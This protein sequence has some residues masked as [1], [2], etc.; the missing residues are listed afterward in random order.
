MIDSVE[1][2]IEM[3]TRHLHIM[4]IVI[5]DEPIGIVKISNKTGYPHH[6]VRYSLR[7]LEETNLIKPTEQGAITTDQASDFVENLGDKV[8]NIQNTIGNMN[9]ET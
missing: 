2:E 4:R 3:V 5:A 8:D 7:A 9:I 6:K 1:K